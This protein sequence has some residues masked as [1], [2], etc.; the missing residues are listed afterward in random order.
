MGVDVQPEFGGEDMVGTSSPVG[1]E[2]VYATPAATPPSALEGADG[3]RAPTGTLS[4]VNEPQLRVSPK[5]KVENMDQDMDS[6]AELP[7]FQ[8]K[9]RAGSGRSSAGKDEYQ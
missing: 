5:R 6:S 9:A 2:N 8:K 7:A 4:P 1:D 3:P